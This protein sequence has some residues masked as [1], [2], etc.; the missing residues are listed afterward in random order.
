MALIL[1]Q[2]GINDY[3]GTANDLAGCVND[4]NEV[5]FGKCVFDS[6]AHLINLRFAVERGLRVAP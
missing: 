4:C 3:P 6:C 1:F 5:V 2:I